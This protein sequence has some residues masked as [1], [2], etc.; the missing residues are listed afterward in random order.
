[1]QAATGARDRL[2]VGSFVL[3]LLVGRSFTTV[4]NS[5]RMVAAV[6]V[7]LAVAGATTTMAGPPAGAFTPSQL[8]ARTLSVGDLPTGWSASTVNVLNELPP[9]V[10]DLDL[11][12]AQEDA[13]ASASFSEGT[14]PLVQE[15]LGWVSNGATADYNAIVRALRRCRQ[16]F[17][18]SLGAIP[19]TGK[20]VPIAYRRYG[21]RSAAFGMGVSFD[22]RGSRWSTGT[23]IVIFEV[24]RVVGMVLYGELGIPPPKLSGSFVTA[25]IDKIEGKLVPAQVSACEASPACAPG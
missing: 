1:L 20:I 6:S 15:N 8:E 14:V 18:L 24:G 12:T 7:L 2:A 21:N 13:T 25:A 23:D 4:R 16:T 5:G 22:Y 9:C 11:T 10:L 3:S 19:A 17:D